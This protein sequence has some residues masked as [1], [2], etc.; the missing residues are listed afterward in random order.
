[1]NLDQMLIRFLNYLKTI[2]HKDFK[3]WVIDSEKVDIHDTCPQFDFEEGMAS[4]MPRLTH[5]FANTVF[6]SKES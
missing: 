5:L 6:E 2:D 3:D 4:V 1:M